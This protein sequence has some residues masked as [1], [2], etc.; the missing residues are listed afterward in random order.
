MAK[1]IYERRGEEVTLHATAVTYG[2][3][4]ATC[5]TYPEA[6]H[7][8]VKNKHEDLYRYEEQIIDIPLSR[9]VR[10]ER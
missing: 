1:V 7:S 6:P 2:N 5:S 3:G 8:M 10:I 9:I 4:V